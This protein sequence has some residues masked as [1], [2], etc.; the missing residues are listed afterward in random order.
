M[1]RFRAICWSWVGVT[2]LWTLS[3]CQTQA[4]SDRHHKQ[5]NIIVFFV[6]DL[7][8][9][10]VSEPFHIQRTP[11]N[12]RYKTPNLERLCRAG[13]KFTQAYAHPVCTPSRVS[14]LTGMAAARDRVTHWTLHPDQPTDPERKGLLRVTVSA[15]RDGSGGH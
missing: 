7:G 1:R 11:W 8:W 2:A 4:E 3:G 12:E 14:L 5:P 13:T 15:H 9:Q 10:D 6:D